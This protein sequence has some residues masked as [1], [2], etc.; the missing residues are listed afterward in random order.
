[1]TSKSGTNDFHGTAY[2]Y[3]RNNI[4]DARNFFATTGPAP[5]FRFNDFGGN[6][7]GPIRKQKTFFFL[8]Y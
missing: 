2:D 5:E 4:L 6:I 7:G 8:N 1:V 3:F